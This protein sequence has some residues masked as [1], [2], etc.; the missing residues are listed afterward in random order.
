[1]MHKAWG[2]IK[3]VPY[4]FQGNPLNF[5]VTRDKKLPILTQIERFRTVTQI[6]IHQWIWSDA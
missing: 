2:N 4:V 3:E 5:K 1:M 6:W